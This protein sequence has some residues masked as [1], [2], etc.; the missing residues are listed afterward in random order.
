MVAHSSHM[1]ALLDP[2]LRGGTSYTVSL[3]RE[4]G[5]DV[6]ILNPSV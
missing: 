6:R 4:N 3:A 1:I 5:L 2:R